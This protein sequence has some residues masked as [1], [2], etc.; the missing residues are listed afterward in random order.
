MIRL[1]GDVIELKASVK[2]FAIQ[3]QVYYVIKPLNMYSESLWII[4][5][6]NHPFEITTE[7]LE[8]ASVAV[9]H[10]I[11]EETDS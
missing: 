3:D 11:D 1:E 10:I 4:S 7:I 8:R 9:A 2:A 5:E 6:N